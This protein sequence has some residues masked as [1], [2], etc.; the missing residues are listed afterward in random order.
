MILYLNRFSSKSFDY[1]TGF[2]LRHFN[3]LK[4]IQKVPRHKYIRVIDR[5]GDLGYYP[6][7]NYIGKCVENLGT[8]NYEKI[9]LEIP[10]KGEDLAHI[11]K[12]QNTGRK[13]QT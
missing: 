10:R 3:I 1:Q 13:V 8:A 11:P 4:T 12:K 5:I 9:T 6:F 2:Y 7:V